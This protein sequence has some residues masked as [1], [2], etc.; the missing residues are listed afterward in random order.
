MAG[1]ASVELQEK[2]LAFHL[3]VAS[4]TLVASEAEQVAPHQLPLFGHR[5]QVARIFGAR[6]FRLQRGVVD[7]EHGV[8]D[9]DGVPGDENKAIA[10]ALFR[11]ADVPAHEAAEREGDQHVDL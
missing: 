4:E 3:G 1:W 6:V 9:R 2:R 8:D 10:E 11:V 7:R 5:H